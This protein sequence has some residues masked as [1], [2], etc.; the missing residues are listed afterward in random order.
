[1]S[2]QQSSDGGIRVHPS[3]LM[4]AIAED[5]GTVKLSDGQNDDHVSVL[6]MFQTCTPSSSSA[7]RYHEAE[8][9]GGARLF[10]TESQAP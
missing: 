5:E 2:S 4:M 9:G 7:K 8:V 3:R 1:L 10:A 6:P